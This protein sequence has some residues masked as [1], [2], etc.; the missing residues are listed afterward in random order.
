MLES[1]LA[2]H[3]VSVSISD[4]RAEIGGN[5]AVVGTWR[6]GSQFIGADVQTVESKLDTWFLF[7]GNVTVI[8][9]KVVSFIIALVLGA[10][11][12][13]FMKRTRLGQA[14]RATAQDARSAR[15]L[16]VN[17]NKVYATTF[18]LNAAIC[19]AAGALVVMTWVIHPFMGLAYTLRSF[20]IVIVAGI[21]NV[22]GVV[23]AGLGLGA[24]E[25][26]AGFILGSEFQAAFVF[27]LL[28]VILVWR[29]FRLR[30]Q[31]RYLK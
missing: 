2:D 1:C 24:A 13:L 17:T 28:V 21:G 10:C 6:R 31:R 9:I 23:V 12:A 22:A 11:L 25:N 26:F 30:L 8:Q 29:N 20:M 14:I 7:D 27:S 4:E 3:R 5:H 19:G 16:G 18:G 15:I